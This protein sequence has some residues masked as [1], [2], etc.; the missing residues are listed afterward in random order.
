MEYT[1]E[2]E[3]LLVLLKRHGVT[4]YKTE[5]LELEFDGAVEEEDDFGV[6]FSG[7]QFPSNEEETN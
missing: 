7:I 1:I 5:N 6:D 4:R 2:L 3:E